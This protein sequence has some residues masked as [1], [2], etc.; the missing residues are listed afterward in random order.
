MVLYTEH[1]YAECRYA[2]CRYAECRYA[3]CRGATIYW[4]LV[5]TQAAQ[6]QVGQ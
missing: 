2:E 1:S 3:E 6:A 5:A 4:H